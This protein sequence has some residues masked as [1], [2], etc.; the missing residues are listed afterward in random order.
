M[1]N[2][3]NYQ[4]WNMPHIPFGGH[5]FA[6]FKL[7]APRRRGHRP[8]RRPALIKWGIVL[9]LALGLFAV[10]AILEIQIVMMNNQLRR[11][12][13]ALTE[14]RDT[15][16]Q[17]A[18]QLKSADE[19]FAG[20]RKRLDPTARALEQDSSTARQELGLLK[21]SLSALSQE[22]S[23]TEKSA[24]AKLER[25]ES[26]LNL[27]SNR[28]VSNMQD[29]NHLKET[30]AQ[31]RERLYE[32]VLLPSVR[33]RA[34][35]GVGGGTII[36]SRPDSNGDYQTYLLTAY[37]VV[38]V[39]VPSERSDANQD[40]NACDQKPTA[41]AHEEASVDIYRDDL[42]A[43]DEYKAEIVSYQPSKDL[44]LLKLKSAK[45]FKSAKLITK[46]NIAGIKVFTPVYAVGCPLG[47]E[48][49][50]TDGQIGSTNRQMN[51][52]KFWLMSA[53]TIFGNSGGGIFLAETNEL[54]GVSSMVCMY[55]QLI[56]TPITHLG[57][58][59]PAENIFNWLDNQNLQFLY[60]PR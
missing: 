59:V 29:V 25:I 32:M 16:R 27:T 8:R 13:A 33:I 52:E 50:P 6:G 22:K 26:M 46:G 10:W 41:I 48:P 44:A 36:S 12:D 53:P 49:M 60:E 37:H 58:M 34:R 54:I 56:P 39:L 42:S 45:P 4:N 57:L 7:P 28:L 38:Q 30:L 47:Y 15:A 51:G 18:N 40:D 35:S 9:G 3:L 23:T 55:N 17:L 31:K 14:S 43:M 11:S 21:D 1:R 5:P 19:T 2:N 24:Q 20:L